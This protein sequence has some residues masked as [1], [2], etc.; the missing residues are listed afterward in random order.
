MVAIGAIRCGYKYPSI[1]LVIHRGSFRS[2]VI[3]HQESG[4]LTCDG[5]L[6][7]SRVI[8]SLK[9]RAKV[10][11]INSS[12]VKPN[13]WIMDTKNYR[14][15]NFHLVVDGQSQWCSLIL[16]AQPCDN[17]LWQSRAVS[18]QPRLP[19]LLMFKVRATILTS[20]M[21]KDHTSLTNFRRFATPNE[22]N[23]LLCCV[24]GDDGNMGQNA[25]WMWP[26]WRGTKCT[27]QTNPK[28]LYP[29]KVLRV[30]ECAQ[31]ACFSAIF[32]LG[33]T[34]GVPQ[35]IGST[36][37][38]H[39]SQNCALLLDGY[40][41]LKCFGPHPRSDYCNSI[42]WSPDNCPKCHLLHNR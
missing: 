39:P 1:K 20:F 23:Y 12:F 8:Y 11:H 13:T 26:L 29:F 30:R 40:Q 38:G 10:L 17:C 9:S 2:F 34:F 3:L 7:I 41:C 35:R 15:H 5:W 24:Y 18:L 25:P 31:T 21:N 27:T 16:A 32:C 42:P 36:S 22:P 37:V 28:T 4:W 14:Q 19:P 6:S 33:L